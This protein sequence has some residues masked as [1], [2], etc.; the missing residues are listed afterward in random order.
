MV[1]PFF[2]FPLISHELI[3]P[4]GLYDLLMRIKRDY[5]NYKAIYIT[6]NG[7][8]Y[9]DDFKNGIIMDEPRIDYIRKYLTSVADAIEDG[10]NVKGYFLWSLMDVFSWSNGYNKR[11]GLF[12]VDFETQ[13]RY[14]KESAYWYKH[15]AETK[16]IL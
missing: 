2:L 4:Q 7:M 16:T 5:P 3:Y 14:P 10:V 11:Y 6:E 9:K 1:F 12:F 13:E 15:L 8:G